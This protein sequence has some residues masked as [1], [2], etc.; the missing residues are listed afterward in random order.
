MVGMSAMLIILAGGVLA[1][2]SEIR[3]SIGN[4]NP[5]TTAGAYTITVAGTSGT[6]TATNTVTLNVQ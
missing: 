3:R 4:S 2:G 5:G 1:C 6:T